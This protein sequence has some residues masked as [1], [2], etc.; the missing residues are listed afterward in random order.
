MQENIEYTRPAFCPD[1]GH[2]KLIFWGKRKRFATDGK[3]SRRLFVRRVQRKGCGKTQA[4]LP[5]F[6]LK[7]QVHL[8]DVILLVLTSIVIEE[9]GSRATSAELGIARSTVRRWIN[10]F[11]QSAE[12][13]YRRFLFLKHNLHPQAPP[14][15]S[16]NYPK[17]VLNLCSQLFGLASGGL[18]ELGRWVSLVTCGCLLLR[19]TING[20]LAPFDLSASLKVGQIID[21]KE[22]LWTKRQKKTSPC[23]ATR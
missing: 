21:L 3:T 20:P 6:L 4:V 16:G 22:V 10:K 14:V 11:K 1:C 15:S 5:A 17:A 19:P 23:F 12:Y 7:N 18:N 9:N 2:D 13:H 8:V